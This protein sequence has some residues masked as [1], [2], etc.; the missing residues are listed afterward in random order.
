MIKNFNRKKLGDLLIEN[1]KI[2]YN[3]LKEALEKQ[4]TTGKRL[5]EILIDS[6]VITEEILYQY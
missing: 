2:T 1:G 4:K 5:G 3:Q 6:G